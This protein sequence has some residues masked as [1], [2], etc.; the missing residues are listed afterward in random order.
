SRV[1]EEL[2]LD[3]TGLSRPLTDGD[4][5]NVFTLSPRLLNAVTLRGNVAT[6][7][8]FEWKDGLH[9][10]DI[11]PERSMLVVPDYWLQRDRAGRPNSWLLEEEYPLDSTTGSMANSRSDV[12]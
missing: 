1:V 10:S 7:V 9:I 2:G 4:L 6:P 8:R 5:V 12:S 11:I 3:A